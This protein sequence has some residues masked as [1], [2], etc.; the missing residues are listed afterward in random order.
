MI[1]DTAL[2]KQHPPKCIRID[3][4]TMEAMIKVKNELSESNLY[5]KPDPNV[6]ADVNLNYNIID[7]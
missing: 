2:Q 7:C 5:N 4:Q 1:I 6:V 3:V